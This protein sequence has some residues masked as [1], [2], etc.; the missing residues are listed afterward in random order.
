MQDSMREPMNLQAFRDA[1]ASNPDAGL[2]W[3]L[4]DGDFV[5]PHFHVTEVGR[6]RKD[7]IDCGGTRR[8]STTCLLQLWVAADTD[9][10]LTTTKLGKILDL[11]TDL[12]EGADVPMEVEYEGVAISQYPIS[13]VEIT[14]AGLMFQLGSKHTDCLAKDRCGLPTLSTGE[15][16][17]AA[18]CG[19]TG[20]C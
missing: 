1:L 6:V 15:E 16:A 19:T 17:S 14:P 9:H 4:P 11:S 13:D 5:P 2:H 8:S 18:S 7:F 3:M 10:R 12:F 20:C